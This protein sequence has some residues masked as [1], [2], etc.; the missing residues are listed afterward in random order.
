MEQFYYLLY[1]RRNDGGHMSSAFTKMKEVLPR[2]QQRKNLLSR[3]S[4]LEKKH[5]CSKVFTPCLI[6]EYFKK[7]PDLI[8]LIY[9]LIHFCTHILQNLGFASHLCST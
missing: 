2:S 4:L 5:F 9:F 6:S 3:I 1:E 8:K 7:H